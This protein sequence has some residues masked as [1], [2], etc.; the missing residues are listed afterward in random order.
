M[1]NMKTLL[2]IKFII[3]RF[4]KNLG[5]LKSKNLVKSG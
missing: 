3:H 2:S 4:V 1:L 5:L